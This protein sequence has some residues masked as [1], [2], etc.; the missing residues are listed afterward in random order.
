MLTQRSADLLVGSPFNI[1]SYSFLTHLLAHHCGY[2]AHEL[3]YSMGNVHI[4]E[5]HFNKVEKIIARTPHPFPTLTISSPIKEQIDDYEPSDFQV[6]NYV[7][8]SFVS[9]PM[10]A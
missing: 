10:V 2:V 9:L 5:Q 3:V 7:H 6:H 4:Y 8:E 1:L